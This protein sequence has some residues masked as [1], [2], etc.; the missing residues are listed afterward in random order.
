MITALS[1][2]AIAAGLAGIAHFLI[3]ERK[4]RRQMDVCRRAAEAAKQ[5]R[6]LLLS[7]EREQLRITVTFDDNMIV[8]S[9]GDTITMYEKSWRVIDGGSCRDDGK[10]EMVVERSGH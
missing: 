9:I 5:A 2:I 8:P 1:C 3:E 4:H 7:Q 6:M 10:V